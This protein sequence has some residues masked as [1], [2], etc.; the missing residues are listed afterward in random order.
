MH[1]LGTHHTHAQSMWTQPGKY[2]HKYSTCLLSLHF[3]HK[4]SIPKQFKSTHHKSQQTT[5]AFKEHFTWFSLNMLLLLF[6]VRCVLFFFLFYLFSNFFHSWIWNLNWGKLVKSYRIYIKNFRCW[7]DWFWF[8]C[9][10]L[11]GVLISMFCG[12]IKNNNLDE[13][14]IKKVS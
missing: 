13:Q 4:F 9:H 11:Q 2:K 5:Q 14:I 10:W 3:V 1:A 12:L 6:C 8:S 7:S